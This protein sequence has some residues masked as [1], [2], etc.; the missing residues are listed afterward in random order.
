MPISEKKVIISS[1]LILIWRD[2]E[3]QGKIERPVPGV[4]RTHPLLGRI[5]RYLESLVP[6]KIPI[7]LVMK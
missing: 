1:T 2:S 3:I 5:P 4:A 6:H 7:F